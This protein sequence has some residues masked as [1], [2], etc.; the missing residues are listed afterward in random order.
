M[1]SFG[2]LE[3]RLRGKLIPEEKWVRKKSKLILA[4]L[5]AKPN[6]LLTKDEI[7]D[8]FFQDVPLDNVDAVYHNTLSNMRTA[9]RI[10]YD[11]PQSAALDSIK[12]I[13]TSV[14][15]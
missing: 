10:D 13:L 3:F 11:F 8:K 15:S 5:L 14:G 1:V 12:K 4:Y 7:I 9:T 6:A 2:R